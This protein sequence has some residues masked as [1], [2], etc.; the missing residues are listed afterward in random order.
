MLGYLQLCGK[1]NVE[2]SNEQ[3]SSD[4]V[5]STVSQLIANYPHII[6]VRGNNL[7]VGMY[8]DLVREYRKEHQITVMAL[9]LVACI[10]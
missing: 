8:P 4:H 3:D 2:G 6:A 5:H 1:V 7:N 10:A 9:M